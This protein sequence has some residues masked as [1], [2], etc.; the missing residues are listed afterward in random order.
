M[1]PPG[2]LV[3]RF[4]RVH[5]DLRISVTDRCNLRCTYCMPLEAIFKPREELL[6]FEEIARVAAVAASLGV[7]SIRL[8]G[9]EPLLRRDLPE[10]VRQLRL[11]AG[12]E[13]LSLTTNG[14]LLADQADDLRHAG[15][16]ASTSASTP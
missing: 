10:L 4:G 8:T 2:P 7:R 1:T 9:G 13:E 12:I 6:A 16:S 15:L 14:L 11:V 3:D 5:T